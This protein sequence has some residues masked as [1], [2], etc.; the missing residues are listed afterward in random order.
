MSECAHKMEEFKFCMS[1]KSMHPEE[2]R[3]IWIRR[4]AKWWARRRVAK[5]SE[6]IWEMR[7]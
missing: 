4:R 6:D 5:S 7:T 2:K 1:I 3:N